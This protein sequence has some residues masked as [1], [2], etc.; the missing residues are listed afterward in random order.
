ML[1]EHEI[2]FR[3]RYQETDAQG[4][5]HHANY[6]KYFEMGRVELLRAAGFSYKELEARGIMLVVAEIRCRFLRG[7]EYDDL[8]RLA[9]RTARVTAVRIEHEYSVFRGAELLAEGGGTIACIDRDG[10]PR[11]LPPEFEP[12]G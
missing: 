1:R 10:R 11:R 2:E 6:L 12:F 8:L 9:T 7:A 4:R 3:V 5:V